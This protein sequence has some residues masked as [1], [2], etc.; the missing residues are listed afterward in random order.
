[1][2]AFHPSPFERMTH[3][4]YGQLKMST[5]YD[6][7]VADRPSTNLVSTISTEYLKLHIKIC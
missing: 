1:M 2:E 6:H 7:D 5:L 3:I 4:Q